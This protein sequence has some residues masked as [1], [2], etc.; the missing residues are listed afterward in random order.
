[1]TTQRGSIPL[2]SQRHP[3]LAFPA[4]TLKRRPLDWP[5]LSGFL[6]AALGLSITPLDPPALAHGEAGGAM[7]LE[8]GTFKLSPLLT[9]EGHGGFE[10]NLPEQPRHYAIDGLVGV[11]MG[12]GLEDGGSIEFEASVGPA[13]VW[14]EAEHFYGRVHLHHH[15]DEGEEEEHAPSNDTPF[16]RTDMKGLFQFRYAPNERLAFLAQWKPYWVTQ[17]QGEDVAGLKNELAFGV[18]WALGDGDVNFALGDGIETIA[19]GLFISI[20]NRSGWESTGVFLGNYTDPWLGL[21]FNIDLLNVIISA[22]PRYYV[23]GSYSGLA[24][25]VDWGGEIELAYPISPKVVL[26]AHWRPIYSTG[27]GEGW[28]VGWVNH[29]GTGITFRF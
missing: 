4:M 23:P 16:R 11:S 29:A 6:A 14:G 27:S 12:W 2:K 1:M 21:G 26:F 25:R 5:Q 13:F 7:K 15:E 10:N 9:I 28:G 8:P 24:S 3:V 19:D 20:V 22:G 18:N 17:T